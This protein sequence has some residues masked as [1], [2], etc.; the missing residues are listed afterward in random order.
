MEDKKDKKQQD[1]GIDVPK[2]NR[3]SRRRMAAN[4]RRRGTR[5]VHDGSKAEYKD[6]AK[7]YKD[8]SYI[9]R[10]KRVVNH[11][12]KYVRDRLEQAKATFDRPEKINTVRLPLLTKCVV[13]NR[14]GKKREFLPDKQPQ[15]KIL[16]HGCVARVMTSD[17]CMLCRITKNEDADGRYID[18]SWAMTPA[19]VRLIGTTDLQHVRR[20][21]FWFLHRYW[22]EVSME[23]RVQPASLFYDYG[24]GPMRQRQELWITREYVPVAKTDKFNDYFRFWK[25]KPKKQ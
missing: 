18:G 20:R 13:I 9:D 12:M 16:V 8:D 6:G 7:V 22:Y 3:K 15:H 1:G 24:V 10:T 14:D 21:P 4:N 19:D 17:V 23:G 11:G 5:L 2:P 25:S